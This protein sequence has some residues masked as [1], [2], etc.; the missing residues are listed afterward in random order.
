MQPTNREKV[1]IFDAN[2]FINLH[3]IDMHSIRL[4]DEVWTKLDEMMTGGKIIS[5]RT[6]YD[7]VVSGSKK[8][9][10]VSAWLQ[11]RKTHFELSTARQIE[12]MANV[13]NKFPKLIDINSERDQADPWLVALA[14]EKIEQDTVH[15]YVVVTQESQASTVKLPAACK[16]FGVH[17]IPLAEFFE[18]N[19]ITFGVSFN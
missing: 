4:P 10:K 16:A 19:G 15:E 2:V 1:Y 11:P 8:P 13:V 12:V 18:E 14:A 9:D 5:H 3:R 6:V 17:S 7:E